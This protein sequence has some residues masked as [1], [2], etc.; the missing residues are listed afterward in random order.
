MCRSWK[1]ML[2]IIYVILTESSIP[3][4]SLCHGWIITIFY[5]L[6]NWTTPSWW[7]A[8]ATRIIHI[9]ASTRWQSFSSQWRHNER[10]GVSN[11]QPHDCWL[12]RLFMRKSKKISKLS[13]TGLCE[14]NSPVTGESPAQRASDIIWFI[15]FVV[16]G[17]VRNGWGLV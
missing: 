14:R 10:D 11:H 3:V 12:S 16:N 2:R 1:Q 4:L 17:P 8:S 9:E 5:L 13:V 6:G 15:G 7:H